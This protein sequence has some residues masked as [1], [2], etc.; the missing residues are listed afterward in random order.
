MSLLVLSKL[1]I[2]DS[3]PIMLVK[4]AR[5]IMRRAGRTLDLLQ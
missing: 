2:S 3:R 1:W 5:R 4:S